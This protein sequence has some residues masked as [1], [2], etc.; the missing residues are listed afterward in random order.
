LAELRTLLGANE[1][2]K[3]FALSIDPV[4]RNREL[5]ARIAKDGNGEVNYPILSDPG[6]KTID[7]YG[8]FDTDYLGQEFEGI[9]HPTVIVIDAERKV[10]WIK[11]EPNYRKRP[12]NA[13]IRAE[14]DKMR[15]KK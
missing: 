6:H 14:I 2:V 1:N 10:Q 4:E 13:E 15:S 3:L 7:A 5:A 9:P 12:S 8:L 11:V